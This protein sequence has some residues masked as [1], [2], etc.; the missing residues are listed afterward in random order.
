MADSLPAYEGEPS[1]FPPGTAHHVF[2]WR[3]AQ[4]SESRKGGMWENGLL[5]EGSCIGQGPFAQRLC[6]PPETKRML[7]GIEDVVLNT[8]LQI[9]E[10]C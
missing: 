2:P 1:Q 5:S 8:C 3:C 4:R 7:S 10:I 9:K 6:H